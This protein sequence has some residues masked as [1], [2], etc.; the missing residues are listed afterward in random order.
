MEFHKCTEENIFFLFFLFNKVL[1]IKFQLNIRTLI[2]HTIKL[3]KFNKEYF[4]NIIIMMHDN[5]IIIN[6]EYTGAVLGR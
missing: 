6:A 3:T 1:L 5:V 2:K 4:K